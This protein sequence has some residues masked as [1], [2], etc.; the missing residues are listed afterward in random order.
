MSEQQISEQSIVDALLNAAE[1][2]LNKE[3]RT[4][5]VKRGDK[6]FFRFDIH[7][8]NEDQVAK[9]QKLSTKNRGRRNEETDWSRYSAHVIYFATTDDDRKRLWD[10]KAVWEALDCVTGADVVYKCLTPAERAKIVSVIEELSGY[11]DTD[12]DIDEYIQKK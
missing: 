9:A 10:N 12:I 8:V 6:E 3:T 7:A 4:I 2:R 1:F 11:D 5:V